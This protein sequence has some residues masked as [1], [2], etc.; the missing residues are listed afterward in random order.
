M[1]KMETQLLD[2]LKVIC[3]PTDK[4]I[5]GKHPKTELNTY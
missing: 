5:V 2:P 4:L 3:L 1:I